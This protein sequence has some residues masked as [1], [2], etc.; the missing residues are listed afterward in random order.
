MCTNARLSLVWVECW[1]LAPSCV[2]FQLVACALHGCKSPKWTVLFR[3]ISARDFRPGHLHTNVGLPPQP[4]IKTG[5]FALSCTFQI[6]AHIVSFSLQIA[7]EISKWLQPVKLRRKA[8]RRRRK[9]PDQVAERRGTGSEKKAT[10]STSTRCWNKFIPTLASQVVPCQSWT[11]SSTTSSNE[12]P[13][14]HLAYRSTT[15]N[16][17]SAAAKCRQL[18]AFS[19]P[20][21]WQSMLWAR[22]P[23]R[24][25]ST[26][27]RNKSSKSIY[28]KQRPFS[29]PQINKKE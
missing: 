16:L 22:V 3:P 1:C 11:A 17:Q 20:E 4:T 25:R 7:P 21:N 9:L 27:L 13:R 8:P 29:G 18:S 28:T 26:P 23:K 12:S 19:Y 5:A 2:Q 15:R 14:K 6:N 24:W 10:A